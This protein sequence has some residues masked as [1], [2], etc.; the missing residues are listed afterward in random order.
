MEFITLRPLV[1][2]SLCSGTTAQGLWVINSIDPC[3]LKSNCYVALMLSY[4]LDFSCCADVDSFPRP[5]HIWHL[6]QMERCHK[7]S[8]HQN[9]LTILERIMTALLL[10]RTVLAYHTTPIVCPFAI[11]DI[12]VPALLLGSGKDLA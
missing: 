8:G 5:S 11:I 9:V 3:V 12:R 2:P 4:K 1:A 6:C 7:V 10:E